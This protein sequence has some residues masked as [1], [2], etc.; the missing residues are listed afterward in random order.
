MGR[1]D[2]SIVS[3]INAC[4]F[5]FCFGLLVLVLA[6]LEKA[7]L[8]SFGFSLFCF[9]WGLVWWFLLWIVEHFGLWGERAPSFPQFVMM[10]LVGYCYLVKDFLTIFDATSLPSVCTFCVPWVVGK[11]SVSHLSKPW[12]PLLDFYFS[13]FGMLWLLF[14]IR[15]QTTLL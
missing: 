10:T 11:L 2:V 15:T 5:L 9:C 6:L 1:Y 8:W 4:T 13:L 14:Q 7:L 12:Y 3:R